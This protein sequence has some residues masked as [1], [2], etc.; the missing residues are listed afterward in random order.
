MQ[1]FIM[2]HL[3]LF[4][5]FTTFLTSYSMQLTDFIT[6]DKNVSIMKEA[7]KNA[8]KNFEPQRELILEKKLYRDKKILNP[9]IKVEQY[10]E[11][12]LMRLPTD[13]GNE[14]AHE[15]ADL[16]VAHILYSADAFSQKLDQEALVR[17]AMRART[18]RQFQVTDKEKKEAEEMVAKKL[19]EDKLCENLLLWG[20]N[21]ATPKKR[22]KIN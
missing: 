2:K 4:S 22:Y 12:A 20:K 19:T 5:L 13:T 7:F 17:L 16:H 9:V 8:D 6:T 14:N 3:V 21:E 15:V 1:R 18:M 11:C 10:I